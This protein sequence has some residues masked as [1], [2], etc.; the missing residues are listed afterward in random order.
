MSDMNGECLKISQLNSSRQLHSPS[1]RLFPPSMNSRHH[2]PAFSSF[3]TPSSCVST[4]CL[5]IS[6]G[7]TILAFK[8]PITD[9]TSLV[10]EFS[11]FVFFFNDYKEGK[12][13]Y[14]VICNP[15]VPVG[16]Q[17]MTVLDTGC[18][19]PA[20]PLFAICSYFMDALHTWHS[21]QLTIPPGYSLFRLM[22]NN[23]PSKGG[24]VAQ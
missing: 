23:E 3:V 5:W 9:C 24:P 17:K 13:Y 18:A 11:I 6:S 1:R 22:K 2:L 8:N 12:N 16:I 21:N 10:A 4:F 20:L 14:T 19:S 7:R 15:H